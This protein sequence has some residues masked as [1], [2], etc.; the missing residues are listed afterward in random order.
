MVEAAIIQ[1]APLALPC[2][3]PLGPIARN[4]VSPNAAAGAVPR[5]LGG[6]ARPAVATLPPAAPIA[7]SFR[8][9]SP[10]GC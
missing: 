4:A 2:G 3:E 6:D 8:N 5:R 1:E 7:M 9:P 10:A